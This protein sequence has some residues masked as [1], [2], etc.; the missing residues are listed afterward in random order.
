MLFYLHRG[1][2]AVGARGRSCSCAQPST[3]TTCWSRPPVDE[4]LAEPLED[5]RPDVT[6]ASSDAGLADEQHLDAEINRV[7]TARPSHALP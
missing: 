3:R 7:P 4:L 2:L 6:G 5:W 1:N